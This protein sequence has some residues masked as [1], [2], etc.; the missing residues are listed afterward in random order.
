M[1]KH[2]FALSVGLF[3]SFMHLVWSIFVFA[4]WA[5]PIL[6]F[7]QMMH[8]IDAPF[9]ILPFSLIHAFSLIILAFI[10]PYAIGYVFATIWNKVHYK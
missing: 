10:I 3:A 4:G 6:S 1:N 5:G 8:F 9:T 2:T 7:A